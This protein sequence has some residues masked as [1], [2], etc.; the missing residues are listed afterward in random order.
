MARMTILDVLATL[1]I[2][3]EILN[4]RAD[5]F[6]M[7]ASRNLARGRDAQAE[8]L[9]LAVKKMRAAARAM[10]REEKERAKAE[11]LAAA[12]AK[13]KTRG[14]KIQETPDV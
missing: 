2:T 5:Y 1:D 14:K 8:R 11:K 6:E 13:T 10:S 4:I 7:R 12:P 3:P 9:A